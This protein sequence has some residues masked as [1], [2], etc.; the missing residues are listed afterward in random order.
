MHSEVLSLLGSIR[1]VIPNID[2]ILFDR[3][4]Y[5]R[6]LMVRLSNLSIPYLIFVP[7]RGMERRELESMSLGE[8]KTIVHQFSFH[9]DN[10]KI[11]GIQTGIPE[12]DI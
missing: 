4:F 11:V 9:S 5:S 1:T 3:G 8:R 6:E 10:R 2:L 12:E 7:K